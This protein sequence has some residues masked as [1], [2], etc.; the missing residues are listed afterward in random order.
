MSNR[1]I[2]AAETLGER[3]RLLTRI[4]HKSSTAL[5][6]PGTGADFVGFPCPCSAQMQV[7]FA[8]V[9]PASPAN[10]HKT[11]TSTRSPFARDEFCE[12]CG[13]TLFPIKAKIYTVDGSALLAFLPSGASGIKAALEA[14]GLAKRFTIPPW[15]QTLN[16][17]T[18]S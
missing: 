2:S 18:S 13:L 15:P 17:I 5:R 3:N 16:E 4:S 10:L 8:G 12:I 14:Q 9:D 11:H 6:N 1:A 7:D